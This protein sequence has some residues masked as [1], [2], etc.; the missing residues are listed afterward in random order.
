MTPKR[1]PDVP[2]LLDERTD[3]S[4]R[5]VIGRLLLGSRTADLALDRVR[6]AVLDLTEAEMRAPRR[7]RVL[8][9]RLDASMLLDAVAGNGR[10]D[11]IGGLL[12]W[13]ASGRLQVRS[14]GF[15]AWTPD[16]SVFEAADGCRTAL[17]GAH[18]FGSPQ[19]ATE[20][21]LTVAVRDPEACAHLGRRFDQVWDRA[22]DVAPAIADVLE[23]AE[24][25]AVGPASAR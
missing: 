19:L 2:L 8:L 11:S 3:P 7:C 6:I 14:A 4:L 24:R 15:G 18:Y 20:P 22:H 23:R 17:V 10:Q 1:F 9:G 13:L 21:S 12:N 25:D 5:R 16:F